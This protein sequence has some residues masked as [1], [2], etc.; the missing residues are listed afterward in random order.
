MRMFQKIIKLVVNELRPQQ[1]LAQLTKN[2][3]A[4]APHVHT[5]VATHMRTSMWNIQT[6]HQK[7]KKWVFSYI[8]ITVAIINRTGTIFKQWHICLPFFYVATSFSVHSK[9]RLRFYLFIYFIFFT[10][11]YFNSKARD[12]SHLVS[13]A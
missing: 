2:N 6:K 4:S 5:K 3:F 10:R 11:G 13:L 9:N 8:T 1:N 12:W 7:E